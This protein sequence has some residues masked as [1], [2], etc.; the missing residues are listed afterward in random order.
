MLPSFVLKHVGKEKKARSE[1][2]GSFYR[3][4]VQLVLLLVFFERNHKTAARTLLLFPR[5]VLGA[6]WGQIR[7]AVS[8]REGS[9]EK[10]TFF[11]KYTEIDI[12]II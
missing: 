8:Y 6:G 12:A 3:K 2:I 7:P 5:A 10:L 9:P 1:K 11:G 4:N